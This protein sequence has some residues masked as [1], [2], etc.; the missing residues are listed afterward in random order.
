MLLT[1]KV[2]LTSQFQ[3]LSKYYNLT[4]ISIKY[5]LIVVKMLIII[6]ITISMKLD[7]AKQNSVSK[8]HYVNIFYILLYC[9]IVLFITFLFEE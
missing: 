9:L 3:E 2:T 4:M 6:T 8:Q 1:I 7:L 5:S